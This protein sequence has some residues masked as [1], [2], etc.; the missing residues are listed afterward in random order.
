M[1]SGDL[2]RAALGFFSGGRLGCALWA[3]PLGDGFFGAVSLCAGWDRKFFSHFLDF[4]ID[5]YIGR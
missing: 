4:G 5:N 3:F 2:G 1:T